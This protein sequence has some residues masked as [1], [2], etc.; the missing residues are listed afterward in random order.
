MQRY[1]VTTKHGKKWNEYH[2]NATSEE[3]AR[4]RVNALLK[5]GGRIVAV[6]PAASIPQY[7]PIVF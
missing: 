4:E 1:V 7:Q 5:R 6:V 3:E 2:V